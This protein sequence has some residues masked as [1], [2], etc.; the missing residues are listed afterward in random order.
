MAMSLVGGGGRWHLREARRQ[1]R[2]W[3]ALLWAGLGGWPGQETHS[4]GKYQPGQAVPAAFAGAL[5]GDLAWGRG[6]AGVELGAWSQSTPRTRNSLFLP[7]WYLTG[8]GSG[9]HER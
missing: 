6:R 4:R 2:G 3:E 1:A 9:Q 7:A 5:P 8:E